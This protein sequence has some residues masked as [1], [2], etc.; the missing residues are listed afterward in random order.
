L[1]NG[2]EPNYYKFETVSLAKRL[3]TA[4]LLL[5]P[6]SGWI[7]KWLKTSAVTSRKLE[8]QS[9][10]KAETADVVIECAWNTPGT[11]LKIE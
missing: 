10:F 6:P 11:P 2:R 7:Q 1:E 3:A 4:V 5:K 8:A 9:F